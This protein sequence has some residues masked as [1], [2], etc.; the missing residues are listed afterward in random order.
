MY[1]KSLDFYTKIKTMVN[2]EFYITDSIK[3]FFII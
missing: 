3:R 2:F 1:S